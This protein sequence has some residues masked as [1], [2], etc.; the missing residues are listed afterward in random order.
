[1]STTVAKL[2]MGK[3]KVVFSRHLDNGDQVVILNVEKIKVTGKKEL[4][5]LYHRHSG[6]GG[7][8]KKLNVSQVREAHPNRLLEHAISG[9][10]PKNK[11]R[12]KMLTRLHL[13]IGSVNPYEQYFKS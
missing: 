7:G 12:A 4:E 1:F 5:K 13:I 11:L 3:D 8:Y 6:F 10:L 9:M 2:L